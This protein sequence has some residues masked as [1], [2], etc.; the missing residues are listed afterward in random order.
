MKHG[1]RRKG[2]THISATIHPVAAAHIGEHPGRTYRNSVDAGA[3]Q[4]GRQDRRH[5]PTPIH[6][7]PSGLYKAQGK[8]RESSRRAKYN[9]L[10][11]G[12][13]IHTEEIDW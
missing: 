8:T 4:H 11:E 5:R 10:G 6:S 13:T 2:D 9:V 1:H 7:T 3:E 12:V